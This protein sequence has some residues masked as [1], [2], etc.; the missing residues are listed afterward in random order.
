MSIHEA[1]LTAY[2]DGELPGGEGERQRV[3]RALAASPRLQR[4]LDRLRRETE[5][6]NRALDQLAAGEAA[7]APRP[8]LQRLRAHLATT[9]GG[10]PSS[11]DVTGDAQ[12]VEVWES[13]P[14]WAE[15][16]IG[17]KSLT[18]G[19]RDAMEGATQRSRQALAAAVI[20]LIPLVTLAV[21]VWLNAVPRPPEALRLGGGP[22][23]EP[24]PAPDLTNPELRRGI[25]ADPLGDAAANIERIQAMGLEWVKFQMAWQSVETSQGSYEW[26]GWDALIAA[27]ADQGIQVLLSI[28]KAPDW[29]RPA[30]DDKSVAG[31]PADAALY[32]QF[33]ARVAGRYRG[34]VGAI[35]IWDEE[36]MWYKAGG[37]GRVEAEAYGD[38]LRQAYQA[39]KA[40]NEDMLVVSGGMVPADTVRDADGQ[41]LAVNDVD[42][43]E[44]LYAAGF[45][46]AFDVL[47]AHAP[48]Y[49]CPAL[50]DW[51]TFE[52]D[53]A[54][55]RAPF[56]TRHHSWCFLGPLQAYRE[57]MLAHG[58]GDKPVWVTEF[59]WAVAESP[60]PGY[61]FAADNT[62]EEQAQW[63]VDAYRW[64]GSQDWVGAMFLWNLDYSQTAPGIAALGYFSIMDTPAYQTLVDGK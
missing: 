63:I 19:R 23:Q 20:L 27:Y 17:L 22:A 38:L 18:G 43:L 59:G 32:A 10:T 31:F 13:P 24:T 41:V 42:Y 34:Q 61:E 4:Q 57:V 9:G 60:Q 54:S 39:I 36:N 62:P 48:G 14:L 33:V 15:I 5:T 12:I 35:E 7:V 2:L 8:A 44:G 58:D 40:V 55:F 53:T 37:A 64:A 50:A 30:G 52:D 47:G 45:G 28:P 25:Q 11:E 21:V 51:Q 56:E 6:V 46:D 3:E 49:N 1:D 16:K 26:S 29:A